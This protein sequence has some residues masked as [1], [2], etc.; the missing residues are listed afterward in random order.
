M[1]T[2]T[3]EHSRLVAQAS[4]PVTEI[5]LDR[6]WAALQ[7][8]INTTAPAR[9]SR[10]ARLMIG[11]GVAAAVVSVSGVAAAGILGARTGEYPRDAEDLRLGGP[12]ERLDPAGGD[13]R[14]VVE[15]EIRDIPFPSL[16]ARKISVD[17]HV[18]GLTAAKKPALVTTGAIRGW[19]AVHAV[20]SWANEWVRA[21]DAGDATA[22]AEAAN[23]LV[24]ARH[25]PAITALDSVQRNGTLTMDEYDPETGQTTTETYPDP[26]Q[27]YFLRLV[28]K[29]VKAGDVDALGNTLADNAYCIGT[30]LVPDF[31]QALPAGF[32]GR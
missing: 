2:W 24:E 21:G 4:P 15:E 9:R 8:G 12:G 22:E 27:Y 20:C 30:S 25:W 1:D 23:M 29:A 14:Q 6:T 17:D 3:N 18:R 10:K 7:P 32:Q 5:D 26:T 19:T 28:S 11:A 13:F 31:Q 16:A